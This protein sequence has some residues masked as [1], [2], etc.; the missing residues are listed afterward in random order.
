MSTWLTT[1]THA[2]RA[3]LFFGDVFYFPA[4][5]SFGCIQ[6]VSVPGDVY[7]QYGGEQPG[8]QRSD[9]GEYLT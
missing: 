4:K 9:R 8:C 6:V 7:Q 1:K 5:I 3:Y 2:V